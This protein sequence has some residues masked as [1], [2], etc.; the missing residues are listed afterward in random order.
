MKST[1]TQKL[2]LFLG[3]ILLSTSMIIAQSKGKSRKH[4]GKQKK[5]IVKKRTPKPKKVNIKIPKG[6]KPPVAKKK[7]YTFPET[8][9]NRKKLKRLRKRNKKRKKGCIAAM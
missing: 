6:Y 8:F 5:Q 1:I 4:C 3:I 7:A 2:L 9:A